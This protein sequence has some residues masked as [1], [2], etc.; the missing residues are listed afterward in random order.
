MTASSCSVHGCGGAVDTRGMCAAHY[1]RLLKNGDVGSVRVKRR[2]RG[3]RTQC[4]VAGC[5]REAMG[6]R[7]CRAHWE[8]VC[9]TGEPGSPTINVR[10]KAYSRGQTCGT[11]GCEAPPHSKGKCKRHYD[12]DRRSS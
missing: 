5:D 3:P 12:Q 1:R 8:R 11:S 6:S 9:Q 10:S 4:S 7:M 2:N